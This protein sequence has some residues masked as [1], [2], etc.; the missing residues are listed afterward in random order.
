MTQGVGRGGE[1][2]RGRMAKEM[3]TGSNLPTQT[4][5]TEEVGYAEGP[6]GRGAG[7]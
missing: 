5:G 1:A 6:E 4:I 3:R 2:G 7:E